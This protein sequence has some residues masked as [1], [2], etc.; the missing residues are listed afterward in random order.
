M[1][2]LSLAQACH[3]LLLRAQGRVPAE[4]TDQ[5]RVGV[6]AGLGGPQLS[7][8]GPGSMFSAWDLSAAKD[9]TTPPTPRPIAVGES[10]EGME[11]L[12]FCCGV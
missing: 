10:G 11:S 6:E 2:S 3:T 8:Q 4:L 1:S 9:L 7:L 12:L 5:C